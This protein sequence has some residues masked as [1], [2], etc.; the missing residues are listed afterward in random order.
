MKASFLNLAVILAVL[1]FS[2][3]AS[4]EQMVSPGEKKP[5]EGSTAD[6]K[7]QSPYYYFIEAELQR[8]KGN[9]DKAIKNLNQAIELD[10]ASSYLEMELATFYLLRKDNNKALP[11]CNGGRSQSPT[12]TLCK[13]LGAVSSIS[14]RS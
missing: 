9:L 14:V 1:F 3:C 11:I 13:L 4:F 5:V 8:K 7:S 12:P 6:V 2:G 10:P